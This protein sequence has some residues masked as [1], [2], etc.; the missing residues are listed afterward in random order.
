VKVF[1]GYSSLFD[2][3]ETV[4]RRKYGDAWV[5][6]ETRKQISQ[7]IPNNAEE[8]RAKKERIS[9]IIRRRSEV[10]ELM[11][12]EFLGSPPSFSDGVPLALKT[13]SN[14]YLL[15]PKLW[16]DDERWPN[17]FKTGKAEFHPS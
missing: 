9:K 15:P 16:L 4:G 7:T 6:L 10:A 2:A 13:D 17:M 11:R 5:D 3:V 8:S 1:K 14:W 12:G